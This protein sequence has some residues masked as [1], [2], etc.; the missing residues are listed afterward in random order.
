MRND[1]LS[2]AEAQEETR[3]LGE[4]QSRQQ[5]EDERRRIAERGF[6]PGPVAV[7]PPLRP[8]RRWYNRHADGPR[9][10]TPHDPARMHPDGSWRYRDDD[11]NVVDPFGRQKQAENGRSGSTPSP[12]SLENERSE[13]DG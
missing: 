5:G 3:R 4:E 10:P 9:E 11:G 12:E 8:V 7:G 6:R 1:R 2:P 13:D